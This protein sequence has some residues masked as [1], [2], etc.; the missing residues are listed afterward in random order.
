[1]KDSS[2]TN[3]KPGKQGS[4]GNIFDMV[5]PALPTHSAIAKQ[6]SR[7]DP[8]SPFMHFNKDGGKADK[9]FFQNTLFP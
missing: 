2:G 5:T 1:M 7:I 4:A 3:H 6:S 9:G 8:N